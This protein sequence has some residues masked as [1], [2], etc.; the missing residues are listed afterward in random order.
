MTTL[1][2]RGLFLITVFLVCFMG[3]YFYK[4]VGK[5]SQQEASSLTAVKYSQPNYKPE[6]FD[7][8]EDPIFTNSDINFLRKADEQ[9]VNLIKRV[10]QSVVCI[11]TEGL[12]RRRFQAMGR[13]AEQI[14]PVRDVGS[15]VVVSRQGHIVTNHHVISGK[16]RF[17][18]TMNDG[19]EY[20]AKLVGTD[21]SLDIA[22]LRLKSDKEDFKPMPFGDSDK[23]E[24][25]QSVFA[26]GNPFGLGETVTQGIISA[27]ERS[28]SD[29]QRDLFQTDAAIN[30]GNSGGPLV[31]VDGTIIGINVAIFSSD[32][33][34]RESQGVGFS[35]PSN[36][37]LRTFTQIAERGS[38]I[39]GYLGVRLMD[40][41]PEV[42]VYLDYQGAGVAVTEVTKGS[43][44]FLAGVRPR[45]VIITYDGIN[46]QRRTDLITLIKNSSITEET[47]VVISRDGKLMELQARVID[48]LES[49]PQ[50]TDTLKD[51]EG[52][53]MIARVASIG[54]RVRELEW[55][56]R[57][58][59]GDI[60]VIV[61]SITSGSM[62]AKTGLRKGDRVLEM[63]GDALLSPDQFY[64][65]IKEAKYGE[66]LTMVLQRNNQKVR[67]K[68]SIR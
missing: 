44:A 41:T 7:L 14:L 29:Q 23:V 19:R 3:A 13:E 60:G 25:G 26:V 6:S 67:I 18:V 37:V 61:D 57:K 62:A 43:P 22:V 17:V 56:E 65:H 27:K 32:D 33:N 30:P 58:R 11:S 46:I 53:A 24:V 35:I 45:D 16:Q 66:P 55:I 40:L 9:R 51:P 54:L 8:Q 52:S 64:R 48:A 39:H 4:K 49:R 38:P 63:N 1:L 59:G 28:F 31:A 12:Q 34:Q 42:K 5:G 15:G 50:T 36:D 10:V 47:I 21:P 20:D 2:Q 68:F